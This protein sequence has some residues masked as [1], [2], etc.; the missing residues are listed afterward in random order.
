[1]LV[2]YATFYTKIISEILIV[3]CESNMN[4]DML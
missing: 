3:K 4:S 1:M 2:M